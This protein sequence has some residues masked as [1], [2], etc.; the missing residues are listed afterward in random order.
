MRILLAEDNLLNQKVALLM[1]KKIGYEADVVNNGLEV[2]EALQTKPYD[3]V[4]LDLQ[5][6]VMDGLTAAKKIREQWPAPEGPRIIA[7]TAT[8]FEEHQEHL[9]SLAIDCYIPKPIM[10]DRLREVFRE[11]EFLLTNP[12]AVKVLDS[13]II[14]SL[15]EMAGPNGSSTVR[16]I[17]Q[18]YIEDAPNYLQAIKQAHLKNDYLALA[19]AVHAL[20]SSSC[21]LG[22]VALVERC[23][24]IESVAR[25]KKLNISSEELSQL[26]L[27]YQ[28]FIRVLGEKVSVL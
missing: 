24:R 13:Q 16:I 12:A 23:K 18:E 5:M 4:L 20:R 8:L 3:V 17:V 10:L 2:I 27:E 22:A 28:E 21:S 15:R 26:E 9:R 11:M 19:N 6:P 25:L 14:E 1:L 7:I